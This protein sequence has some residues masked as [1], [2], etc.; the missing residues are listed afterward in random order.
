MSGVTIAEL[1]A[2]VGTVC[3]ACRSEILQHSNGEVFCWDP[4][5]KQQSDT[6]RELVRAP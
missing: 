3:P 1:T 5:C 2:L 4:Y 6:Y